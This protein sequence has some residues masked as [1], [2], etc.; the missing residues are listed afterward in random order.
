MFL[1]DSFSV[2]GHEEEEGGRRFFRAKWISHFFV[3]ALEAFRSDV[4]F[5][6]FSVVGF[7]YQVS[8]LERLPLFQGD[9]FPF[10]ASSDAKDFNISNNLGPFDLH[11]SSELAEP[12]EISREGTLR[13]IRV[14]QLLALFSVFHFWHVLFFFYRYLFCRVVVC[15]LSVCDRSVCVSGGRMCMC[16]N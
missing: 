1:L 16:K 4:V 11:S 12:N 10:F 6:L 7:E 14:L 13:S 15:V 2:V 9:F 8:R 3:A 5:H